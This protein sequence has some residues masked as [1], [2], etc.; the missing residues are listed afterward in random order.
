MTALQKFEIMKLHKL[1]TLKN[2][3]VTFCSQQ[4][5]TS[6]VCLPFQAIS[7][8]NMYA[9][10]H[11]IINVKDAEQW[12]ELIENAGR[13]GF[14]SLVAANPMILTNIHPLHDLI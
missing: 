8:S 2:H 6:P 13:H 9:P 5:L 12:E 11:L 4:L 3:V 10:E 7:F 14:Q 1:N